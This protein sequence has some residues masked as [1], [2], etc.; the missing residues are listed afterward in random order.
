MKVEDDTKCF[1]IK[2]FL[3]KL[4]IKW[5]MMVP[6]DITFGRSP[7]YQTLKYQAF[8]NADKVGASLN[9]SPHHEHR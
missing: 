1:Q 9:R 5:K 6:P 8:T 7:L 2:L 4:I 3:N